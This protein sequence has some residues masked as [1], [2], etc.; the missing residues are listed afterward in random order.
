MEFNIQL[1]RDIMSVV[2]TD[3]ATVHVIED[4]VLVSYIYH[5]HDIVIWFIGDGMI[6]IYETKYVDLDYLRT[7]QNYVYYIIPSNKRKAYDGYC[8]KLKELVGE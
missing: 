5:G 7:I 2:R 6:H 4:N 1:I 8:N 3:D